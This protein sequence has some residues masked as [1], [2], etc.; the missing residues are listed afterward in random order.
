MPTTPVVM[1]IGFEVLPDFLRR[2]VLTAIDYRSSGIRIPAGVCVLDPH[3]LRQA[4]LLCMRLLRIRIGGKI[5]TRTTADGGN[6]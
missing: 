6:D 5:V 3:A 2:D 4:F 1:R